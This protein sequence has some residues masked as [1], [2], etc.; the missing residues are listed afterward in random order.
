[1]YALG[2]RQFF[3]IT[4]LLAAI[5]E[6]N[7]LISGNYLYSR[8]M[9]IKSGQHLF[10]SECSALRKNG[11]WEFLSKFGQGLHIYSP[12]HHSQASG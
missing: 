11:N 5:P 6:K 4:L 8:Q 1:M 12:G 2:S 10:F 7:L 3:V 9:P